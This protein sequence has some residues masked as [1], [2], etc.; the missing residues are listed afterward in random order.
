VAPPRVSVADHGRELGTSYE[1]VVLARAGEEAQAREAL[2]ATR[3]DC[4]A[5]EAQLSEWRFDSE[6]SRL[7]QRGGREAVVVSPLLRR[8]LEGALHV[9]EA[10]GGAFDPTWA[11]LGPLWDE[12]ERRGRVP[13]AIELDAARSHLGFRRVRL[14]GGRV[15]FTSPGTRLGLASFAKGWIIDALHGALQRRGYSDAIVNLGG[16]LRASGPDDAGHAQVIHVLDPYRPRAVVAELRIGDAALATS[17]SYFRRRLIGGQAYGHLLDPATGRPPAFDGSVT[18]LTRDAAMADALATALYVM[19]PE[20]GLAFA[21]RIP[22]LQALYATR[23]GLR[24]TPGL[25]RHEGGAAPD[26]GR[27]FVQPRPDRTGGGPAA[28]PAG[29]T[30]EPRGS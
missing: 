24:A 7:N 28:G 10:T 14:E 8:L 22:G 16:D 11:P 4:R 5:L 21:R 9:A 20:A 3:A 6:V 15:R 23:D 27:S 19:G 18:V 30:G 17:G 2:A 29:E 26:G 1:V 25:L 12:A 13:D